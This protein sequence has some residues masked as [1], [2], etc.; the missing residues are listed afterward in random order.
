MGLPWK[1]TKDDIR[2]YFESFGDI[3]MIRVC[4]GK[5]RDHDNFGFI[6][7]ADKEVEKQA[8]LKIT[9]LFS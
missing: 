5:S 9:I 7:F 2:L 4:D 3:L 1:A 6:R 8:S